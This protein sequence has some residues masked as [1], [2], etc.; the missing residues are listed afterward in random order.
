MTLFILTSLMSLFVV[1]NAATLFVMSGIREEE[2]VNKAAEKAGITLEKSVEILE[3]EKK[4]LEERQK[5]YK[6]LKDS[7]AQIRL[8]QEIRAKNVELAQAYYKKELEEYKKLVDAQAEG[9]AIDVDR[10]KLVEKELAKAAERL[11]KEELILDVQNRQ[12]DTIDNIFATTLGISV[13]Q[14]NIYTD[15]L[16]AAAAGQG[17]SEQ[18]NN[19]LDR[20]KQILNPMN[21][22]ASLG[23][24]IFESTVAFALEQ[25]TALANLNK[26]IGAL[27]QYD[28]A[29]TSAFISNRQF[30]ISITQVGEATQTL[31]TSMSSFSN[32]AESTRNELI[33]FTAQ[34]NALG[35]ES[36]ATS[37][38]LEI[39]TKA[40]GMNAEAAMNVQKELFAT[41]QAVGKTPA[42]MVAG[43][44][45]AAPQLA[46]QGD[47]MV[48]V[49]K[50]LSAASKAT[51]I[52]MQ[53]LLG[54]VGKF[55][56]FEGAADAAGSLNAILGG[57]MLNSVELL[58]A[59]EDER[60]RMLIRSIELSGK[61]F[62]SMN[63]FEKMAIANA[64]GITDMAEANKLFNT[65]LSAYDEQQAAA[66]AGAMTQEEMNE[67]MTK[68]MDIGQRLQAAF[69]SLAVSI[70]PFV[71]G[72]AAVVTGF[73]WLIAKITEF[74][75]IGEY[76][77]SL[78]VALG[79]AGIAFYKFSRTTENAGGSIGRGIARLATGIARGARAIGA[80]LA[81][82]VPGVASFGAAAS[83]LIPIV[84]SLAAVAAG[85]AAV[86]FGMGFLFDAISKVDAG[87]MASVAAS[88]GILGLSLASFATFGLLSIPVLAALTAFSAASIVAAESLSLVAQSIREI[89][90]AIQEMEA[91]KLAGLTALVTVAAIPATAGVV[92]AAAFANTTARAGTASPGAAPTAAPVA[93]G[94]DQ[95]PIQLVIDQKGKRVLAE[96]IQ[97]Q[98]KPITDSLRDERSI[99][100]ASTSNLPTT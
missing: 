22:L 4:L 33:E 38:L 80:G 95:R 8:Q 85:V 26:N 2:D 30:G 5:N 13:N 68:F 89:S 50:G 21:I 24:K 16:K 48:E 41:G 92:T 98:I 99:G 23:S 56:T 37:E 47:K 32:L 31:F 6:L 11:E 61:S 100:S 27:G 17:F 78:V 82:A 39:S 12:R 49:F 42:E 63:K 83:T 71:E 59:S 76:I 35:I 14:K 81:S 70:R 44:T 88:F 75:L 72:L 29:V 7:T 79:A 94:V 84:V 96:I 3:A 52:E 90:E 45:A 54:I 91:D 58:T 55:D 1:A 67:A 66:E 40:L 36:R 57:D 20:T 9:K 51:G 46:A 86:F 77:P 64:A 43:F 93:T 73:S 62:D 74:P 19:A 10:L 28:D 18:M 65:T 25:D 87:N 15:A 69:M 60:I 53:S 34:M 97:E